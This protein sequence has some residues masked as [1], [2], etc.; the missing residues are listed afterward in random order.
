M[1]L[2]FTQQFYLPLLLPQPGQNG[3]EGYGPITAS[4]SSPCH[5]SSISGTLGMYQFLP[6]L[7][8]LTGSAAVKRRSTFDMEEDAPGQQAAGVQLDAP[9]QQA[10]KM[11]A[12]ELK[13]L[14]HLHFCRHSLKCSC[15]MQ[16]PLQAQT[17]PTQSKLLLSD[18]KACK[19]GLLLCALSAPSK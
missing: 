16:G 8:S 15:T 13:V 18:M 5:N 3:E 14:K 2:N 6:R 19:F 12:G 11:Q 10:A 4:G 1:S 7:L 9:M 17:N